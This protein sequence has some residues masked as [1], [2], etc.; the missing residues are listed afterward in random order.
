ML[1]VSVLGIKDNKLENYQ[2]IEETNCDYI[3]MDIM[4]G[5]FV[6]NNVLYDKEYLFNKKL[7]IHLMVYDVIK[8]IDFYRDLN[9]SFITFHVE[10]VNNPI[11][12][13]NYLKSLNIKAGISIKP[14]TSVEV[15]KPYLDLVDLV[16]VMSVEPGF[17]GQEFIENST[18]KINEL[19]ELRNS[20][21]YN[22]LIEVD[23]GI[24]DIT[25]KKVNNAD[26]KV[27]GSFITKESDYASQIEKLKI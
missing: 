17:G 23:G 10:A 7:D 22:Y 18:N 14:N 3:H 24:N 2:K 27:V 6:P 9:P 1:S 21:N 16:L 13:I 5:K 4:D 15:I 11:D 8:Y 25:Y 20:N 12:I 19:Y 26:I